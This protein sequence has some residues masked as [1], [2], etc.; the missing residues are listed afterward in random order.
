MKTRQDPRQDPLFETRGEQPFP[1]SL[2]DPRSV[3]RLY[4][5]IGKL[6]FQSVLGFHLFDSL[7]T[8]GFFSIC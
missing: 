5:V 7:L 6:E 8:T 1:F 2:A 4:V 3:C